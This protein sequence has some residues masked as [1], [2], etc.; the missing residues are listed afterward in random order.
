MPA[1]PLIRPAAPAY[2]ADMAAAMKYYPVCLRIDGRPCLVVGG[3]R[4]AARKVE[5][6]LAAGARVTVIA[7]ELAPDLRARVEAGEVRHVARCYQ[8]G[9]LRGYALV[10]AATNDEELHA[11]LAREAERAGVLWNVADDPAHCGFIVPSILSRGDLLVAV[12]TS[13]ASP[14]LARRIR[15]DLD[16][17][18]GPEYDRALALLSNLREAVRERPLD[19]RQ[20]L[21]E[22]LLDADLLGSL[23]AADRERVDRLLAEH[24][25]GAI[26]LASLGVSLD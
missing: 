5:S 14:A 9:D 3:G 11:A 26:S 12:S 16:R 4:V 10:H 13:G 8:T 20:R 1:V 2:V 19:D 18:L 22:R 24:A 25:G 7:P 21:F 17:M 6:L 23:R 15:Q